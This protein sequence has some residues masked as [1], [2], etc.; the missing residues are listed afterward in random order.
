MN[1]EK[2]NVVLFVYDF[3]HKKSEDFIHISKNSGINVVA[4]IGA[5]KKK[6]KIPKKI[7]KRKIELIPL[8]H[9]KKLCEAYGYEYYAYDHN[10]KEAMNVITRSQANLGIIAGAR[11]IKKEIIDLFE[12]GIINFH[13]GKIPEAS[14]LFALYWSIIKG[15][16]P[17]V[18]VHFI[19]ERVDA[20]RIIKE[21]KIEIDIEDRIEDIEHKIY[22]TQLI[23]YKNLASIIAKRNEIS[24]FPIKGY[25]RQNPP[26]KSEKQKEVL[27]L[28]DEWKKRI[29]NR[30]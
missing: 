30:G 8:F 29:I 27:L 22:I 1:R 12:Y 24:S 16:P 6:L 4:C 3:P 18:T 23:E 21:T 26:M 20:G 17:Y 13:P 14:G 2:Y 9:P 15:I 7:Y 28:F 11:I 25:F 19:D 5:P 10:S